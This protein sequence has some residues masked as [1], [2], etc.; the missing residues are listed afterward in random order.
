MS[1]KVH[2][3]FDEERKLNIGCGNA[4]MEGFINVDIGNCNKDMYMDVT[5]PL[6]FPDE[7]FT[8]ISAQHVMEHIPKE[9]F[10]DVFREL[11][12]VMRKGCCFSFCVPH[13][14]SDNYWTDP[15]H[16]MPYT[17]RTMDFLIKGKQLR[18]NGEIYGADY[19]FIELE[20]PQVDGVYTIY[21]KLSK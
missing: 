1:I 12:R 10:W 2:T 13:A 11:H 20:D 18:E 8:E 19:E 17:V 5:K 14:G 16:S 9:S 6:P 21:F 4:P 7:C 3:V 15:T